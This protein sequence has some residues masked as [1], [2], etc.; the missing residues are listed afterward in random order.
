MNFCIILFRKSQIR[1]TKT[2]QPKWT[3]QKSRV[4]DW[5]CST[6]Q[7]PISATSHSRPAIFDAL[8]PSVSFLPLLVASFD[9]YDAV[10]LRSDCRV[11]SLSPGMDFNHLWIISRMLHLISP[12]NLSIP[13]V[14]SPTPALSYSESSKLSCSFEIIISSPM[15][16][17]TS[18]SIRIP[19]KLFSKLFDILK[20]API[21]L[22]SPDSDPLGINSV[23]SGWALDS[24]I[25][26]LQQSSS[27][28]NQ[29]DSLELLRC[30]VKSAAFKQL[31]SQLK[32]PIVI[33][34]IDTITTCTLSLILATLRRSD[35]EII[36]S[37][38]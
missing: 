26:G 8:P 18:N 11:S 10:R 7:P 9:P 19:P 20:K 28:I 13:L 22:Q 6:S 21:I 24:A 34:K 4:V 36:S 25:D 23:L 17:K 14:P 2:S 33:P 32:E 27:S 1:G 5:L 38:Y 35:L 29:I 12:T 30:I 3:E 15:P 31:N 16:S 37:M